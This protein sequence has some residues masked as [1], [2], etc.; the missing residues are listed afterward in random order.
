MQKRFCSE[1]EVTKA[2]CS[3]EPANSR[4][5]LCA[6]TIELWRPLLPEVVDIAGFP[7][8]HLDHVGHVHPVLIQATLLHLAPFGDKYQHQ[9]SVPINGKLENTREKVKGFKYL[10]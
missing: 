5:Q 7:A 2:N 8:S 1:R 3:F 10:F 9:I 6:L 4:P